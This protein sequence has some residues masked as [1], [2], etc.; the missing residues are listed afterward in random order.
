VSEETPAAVEEIEDLLDRLRAAHRS[1]IA[2]VGRAD[3]DRFAAEGQD[4]DSLKRILERSAD[5][6]NFY[7]GQLV[8]RALALPQPPM[9][10]AEFESIADAKTALQLAHRRLTRLLNDISSADLERKTKLES[11]AEYTLRQ[12]LETVVAHYRLRADQLASRN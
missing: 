6:V 2:A 11:T 8:A 10:T 5:D 3:P 1:F 7:Y 4:G 9:E 12:V